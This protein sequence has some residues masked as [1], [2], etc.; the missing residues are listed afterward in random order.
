MAKCWVMV[1]AFPTV[2]KHLSCSDI[3]MIIVKGSLFSNAS[4]VY[5]TA[6][7]TILHHDLEFT[8]GTSKFGLAGNQWKTVTIEQNVAKVKCLIKKN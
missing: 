3:L 6:L 5:Q 7:G 8:S 2:Q 1:T 4:K